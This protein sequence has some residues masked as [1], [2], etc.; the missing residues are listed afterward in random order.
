MADQPPNDQPRDSGPP[1]PQA[2]V[3]SNEPIHSTNESGRSEQDPQQNL[4]PPRGPFPFRLR[5]QVLLA[6]V[7]AVAL[8]FMAAY[9]WR[10]SHWGA[11]P[12]ELERQPQHEYD[13]KID[14]NTATWVEWSQLPGIGPVLAHR[15][16]DEREQ[17]GPFRDIDD[18]HRVKGIGPKRIDAMR[19]YIR[20][21]PVENSDDST[22]EVARQAEPKDSR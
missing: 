2:N 15:I 13:F 17:N 5:D 3:E 10:T 21:E 11:E 18:L 7:S 9:C 8:A 6:V 12:I 20:V 19:P 22:N 1:P 14:L 4:I 16:V